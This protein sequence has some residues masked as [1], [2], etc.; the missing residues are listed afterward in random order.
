MS[1]KLTIEELREIGENFAISLGPDKWSNLEIER[2]SIKVSVPS[3]FVNK[4]RDNFPALNHSSMEEYTSAT[5]LH[6]A[7]LGMGLIAAIDSGTS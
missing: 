2:E 5:I 7:I 1:S 6:F 4:F 3:E